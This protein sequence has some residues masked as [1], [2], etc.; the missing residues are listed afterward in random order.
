MWLSPNSLFD[1]LPQLL[2]VC[3]G[4]GISLILNQWETFPTRNQTYIHTNTYGILKAA[5]FRV[6]AAFLWYCLDCLKFSSL[7]NSPFP[8]FYK[9]TGKMTV[10]LF[11]CNWNPPPT[12][13]HIHTHTPAEVKEVVSWILE[14]E[15]QCV[16]GIPEHSTG[17]SLRRMARNCPAWW[18]S[19]LLILVSEQDESAV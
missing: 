2:C 9:E 17:W 10:S 5:F 6:F 1:P 11:P 7:L 14:G 12:P 15:I 18:I 8:E 16:W 19:E 3:R 13:H 4:M